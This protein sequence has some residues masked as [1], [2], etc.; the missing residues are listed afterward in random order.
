MVP[1]AAL[2]DD[3]RTLLACTTVIVQ[4]FLQPGE[5]MYRESSAS[6]QARPT[7]RRRRATRGLVAGY[8]HEV[9]DRHGNG[10]ARRAAAEARD[11]SISEPAVRRPHEAN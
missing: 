5:T 2:Y 9:S 6:P 7:A 3:R 10:E 11:L 8:I 1:T 4:V